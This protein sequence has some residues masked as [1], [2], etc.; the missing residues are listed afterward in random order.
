[1]TRLAVLLALMASLACPARA[2]GPDRASILLGSHHAAA[3]A[4][5]EGVNPGL[6]LTWENRAGLDWS[7]GAYRNSYGRASVA[8][9]VARPLIRWRGGEAG[10]F[11]GLA[12]YPGNGRRFR[13]S[14]GDVVPLA[15]VQARH[16]NLFAQVIPLGGRAAR[17]VATVGV[18]FDLGGD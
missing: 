3:R 16:G 12:H 1:M 18:T 9:T 8:V 4:A 15:G 6:F 10:V 13:V 5:F 14:A 2:E 7:V 17:A 11:A